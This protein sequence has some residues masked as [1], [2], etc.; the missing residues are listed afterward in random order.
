MEQYREKINQLFPEMVSWRRTL[1]Q[2]PEL[3]FHE[4][5]TAEFVYQF[6]Q[7]W[8]IEVKKNVGGNGVVGYIEGQQPG[9]TVA[10]R[11][12]MD[13]LPIQ[14]QKN[15]S[16]TS[17]VPGV[18]HACGHDAHTSVL[19]GIAKILSEHQDE[20]K[21][22]VKL[23]FQ[24]AEEISPG[25]AKPMIE[26]GVLNGVDVI[27]GVHLWTPMQVGKVAS[28]AGPIMASVDEFRIEIEGKGG[29][30]GLPHETIDSVFVGSQL[31]I[32]LQ[33]IV[34]RFTNPIQP[35]V[36][37]IGSIHAGSNFNIIAEKCVLQGTVRT[38]DETLRS[39]IQQHIERISQHTCLMFG[40][41][42]NIEYKSCYPTVIN[43]SSE[44]DRFFE[45]AQG[46][47]GKES[48]EVCSLM[49]AGEDFSYYLQEIPG[50]FM[51]VGAGNNDLGI[52]FPHHHPKFDIDEHAMKQ[53]AELLLNMTLSY[54]NSHSS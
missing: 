12:D 31:V 22:N 21:G 28:I 48:V 30:A 1:H 15:C 49:M 38:F 47:F 14:D 18:M 19:L 26:D 29:H 42:A 25:G 34:S 44:V 23:I 43:H 16:Y 20:L 2:Q 3:S 27:Y 37:S 40:A 35:S 9:P 10:L 7:E 36:V 17:K 50:C 4:T 13:A 5:K 53:S 41:T 8:G 54:I 51:F 32:N 46:L 33:S 39:Q 45:T 6:L 52:H 24:H 11:A